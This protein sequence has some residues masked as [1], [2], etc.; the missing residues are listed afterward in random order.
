MRFPDSIYWLYRQ[1]T[2]RNRSQ[3]LQQLR[4]EQHLPVAI[5]FYHRV[6]REYVDNPW[7]ISV[8]NFRRHLDWLQERFDLV[9]LEE[10]QR[11]IR[12]PQNER[13]AVS[14][15]FDDGYA[16]N[17]DFAIPELVQ[18]GVPA[19][20]F[21]STYF[22]DSGQPFPHDV[23]IG[24]PLPPNDRSQ[25]HEFVRLGIEIGSHTHT[26]ANVGLI[27]DP[28]QLQVELQGSIQALNEWL[29]IQSKYF[30]FPYGLPA[31]MTQSAVDLLQ[32]LGI[33]GFCSG[34]GALNWPGNAGFHL[35][36]FHADPGIERLKNWLTLDSRKLIDDTPLPFVEPA[37][38]YPPVLSASVAQN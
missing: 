22:I 26:H 14:I 36:R 27:S 19:T 10:A 29:G 25:L 13:T 3:L 9:S 37:L 34:Y 31:N 28:A 30:A 1:M 2:S 18:R 17:A 35:R 38:Q 33:E 16:E 21:V 5:L 15:T 6:A 23:K 20:Y 32:E 11:R 24:R 4:V 12:Q 8:D 7:S